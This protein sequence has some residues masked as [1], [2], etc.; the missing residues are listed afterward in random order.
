MTDQAQAQVAVIMPCHNGARTLSEAIESVA[1]QTYPQWELLIV[2]D[3]STD[4]SRAIIDRYLARDSRIRLLSNPRPSGASAA[5]NRALQETNARYVAFLDSDDTWKPDKVRRQLSALSEHGAALC[6]GAYEVMN[7]SGEVIGGVNPTPGV[8]RYGDV[9]GNN[10]IG[11]LTTM[12]DRNLCGN[13][14]FDTGLRTSEDFY[15]WLTILKRGVIGICLVDTLAS[16]RVHGQTLSGNK[17]VAAKNRWRVYRE[18]EKYGLLKSSFHFA[19][20][21]LT[22]VIKVLEMRK[23][24]LG[25]GA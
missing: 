19:H 14:Q 23:N 10:P 15:L 12:L 6:C 8:L 25:S 21:A 16:Y 4:G 13:I 24:R 18:F 1:G 9:L 7:A 2:D 3:G 20:Y 11:T 17:L 22:G 5:R